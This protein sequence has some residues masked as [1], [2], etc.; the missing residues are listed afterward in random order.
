MKTTLLLL[1]LALAS[2]ST[3]PDGRKTFGG[4]DAVQWGGV[5]VKTGSAYLETKRQATSAK[6]AV[7]VQPEPE[8]SWLSWGVSLLGL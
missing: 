3:S 2:C 1:T 6:G 4:L 5:A 8:T 7:E